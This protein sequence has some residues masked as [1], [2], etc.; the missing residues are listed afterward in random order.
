APAD[1]TAQQEQ[2]IR[3]YYQEIAPQL[4]AARD[5]LRDLQVNLASLIESNR[6]PIRWLTAELGIVALGL[7]PST[8]DILGANYLSGRIS[9]LVFRDEPTGQPLPQLLSETG[10]F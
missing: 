2:V 7:D 4:A 9:R 6:P 8:G 10:A 1:R 5:R 3:A